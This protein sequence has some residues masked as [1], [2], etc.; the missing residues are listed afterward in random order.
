MSRAKVNSYY[1]ADAVFDGNDGEM[2]CKQIYADNF[3]QLIERIEDLEKQIGGI[4]IWSALF[5]YG[6]EHSQVK[7]KVIETLKA[8]N[9]NG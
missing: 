5:V 1:H 9:P 2:K 8:R 3:L 4:E 6:D 7:M